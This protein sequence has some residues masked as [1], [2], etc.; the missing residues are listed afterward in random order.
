VKTNQ[1]GYYSFRSYSG[2]DTYGSIHRK[3]FSPLN[4]LENL[5][6][7]D[8]DN[9]F[10]LQFRVDVRLSGGTT[11]VLVIT[12]YPPKGIGAFSIVAFGV[13]TVVFERLSE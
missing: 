2:L 13:N 7:T 11:Y 6:Q 4:P 9:N 12:T 5:L 10:N 1:S 3:T 8:D